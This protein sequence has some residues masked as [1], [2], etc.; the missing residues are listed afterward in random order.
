MHFPVQSS[1][2]PDSKVIN[3][4]CQAHLIREDHAW[5]WQ[6]ARKPLKPIF[7]LLAYLIFFFLFKKA[8]CELQT[9]NRRDMSM[10]YKATLYKTTLPVELKK[11]IDSFYRNLSRTHR[12]GRGREG[13]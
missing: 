12:C 9:D 10:F 4:I 3:D 5:F 8:L 13:G 2:D 7:F 1:F 11:E 6:Q